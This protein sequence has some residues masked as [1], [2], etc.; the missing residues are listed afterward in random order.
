MKSHL[1][2]FKTKVYNYADHWF[3][4]LHAKYNISMT[5]HCLW[6]WNILP[7]LYTAVQPIW[8]S[9][10]IEYNFSLTTQRLLTRPQTLLQLTLVTDFYILQGRRIIDLAY[11][12]KMLQQGCAGCE[13][14]LQVGGCVKENKYGLAKHIIF[15]S[16]AINGICEWEY[17][18]FFF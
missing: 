8:A 17:K 15:I 11:F 4:H 12:A 14:P 6:F 3:Y 18:F 16:S 7:A 13:E 9:I 10:Y 5:K 1:C 2:I